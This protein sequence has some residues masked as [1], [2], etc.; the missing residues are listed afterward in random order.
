MPGQPAALTRSSEVVPGDSTLK[1]HR[2]P[3]ALPQSFGKLRNA[4][5]FRC[6]PLS[7]TLLRAA[8]QKSCPFVQKLWTMRL[9]CGRTWKTKNE[10]FAI[11]VISITYT[12]YNNSL[13]SAME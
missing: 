12:P 5:V 2:L 11:R 7:V 3:L 4:Y 1:N 8:I 6:N 10:L 9:P 13:I